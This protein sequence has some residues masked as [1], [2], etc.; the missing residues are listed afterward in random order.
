MFAFYI[1]VNGASEIKVALNHLQFLSCCPSSCFLVAILEQVAGWRL[2]SGS[3]FDAL[4]GH[5][6]ANSR[7]QYSR[8]LPKQTSWHDLIKDQILIFRH[9]GHTVLLRPECWPCHYAA[10]LGCSK[11]EMWLGCGV[12][13]ISS[14]CPSFILL[15]NLL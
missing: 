2:H 4:E 1:R 10:A 5:L 7:L 8:F 3:A 15:T 14:S 11:L 9:Q 6:S 12:G 13:L